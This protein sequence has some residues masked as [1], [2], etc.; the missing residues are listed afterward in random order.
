MEDIYVVC[1]VELSRFSRS[2]SYLYSEAMTNKLLTFNSEIRYLR[3]LIIP[4]TLA[5]CL[6]ASHT[7]DTMNLQAPVNSNEL[8]PQDH[9]QMIQPTS[10]GEINICSILAP[11]EDIRGHETAISKLKRTRKSLLNGHTLPQQPRLADE[12][13]TDSLRALE[14]LPPEVLGDIFC[15][16]TTPDGFEKRSCNF[17]LVCHHWYEVASRTPKLWSFWGTT[18]QDWRERHLRYPTTPLNLV[19]DGTQFNGETLDATL[20]NALRDRASWDTIRRIHLRARDWK[21]INSILFPLVPNQEVRYN[22]VESFILQNKGDEPVDASRFFAYN[23]L[24]TLV[25]H[26]SYFSPTPTTLQ[27]LSMLTSIPALRKLVLAGRSVPDDGDGNPSRVSL[28]HLKEL[29]LA[30][31]SQGVFTLLRRLDRPDYMDHLDITLANCA[32]E[33]I[34]ETFGPYLRDY[35]RRRGRSQNDLE[36][37]I[38]SKGRIALHVGDIGSL[39]PSTLVSKQVLP[40]VAITID[41]YHMPPDYSPE[42]VVLDIIVHIPQEEIV[43]LQTYGNPTAME[44]IYTRSPNLRALQSERMP[45]SA[46]VPEPNPNGEDRF[47]SSLQYV[48]FERLVGVDGDWTPL[49]NFLY[50]RPSSGKRLHSLE[51][52]GSCNIHPEVVEDIRGA[53]QEFTFRFER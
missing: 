50:C 41:T 26:L 33:E 49:T 21:L 22:S 31:E 53:V 8:N 11:E 13:H 16:S 9:K 39:H 20:R 3:D 46:V 1:S 30:G 40:F 35:F 37:F 6:S 4:Q 17:L 48:S 24:T 25:L 14:G 29:K 43:Y 28:P 52:V 44:N 5:F 15:R 2:L 7:Q 51:M 34:P 42:K 36:L 27:L 45:L 38:S 12:I 23:L 19:L 32:V 47:L 18:L 10:R